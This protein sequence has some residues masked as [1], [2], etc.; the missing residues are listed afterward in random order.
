MIVE[1]KQWEAIEAIER[2]RLRCDVSGWSLRDVLHPS[3][4]VGNYQRY[5]LDFHTAFLDATV[6]L[7]ACSYLHNLRY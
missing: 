7:Q 1:L 4:Q 6:G 5:L 2:R 3:K